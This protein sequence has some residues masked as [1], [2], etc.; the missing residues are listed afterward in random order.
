MANSWASAVP[1]LPLAALAQLATFL[2]G[3]TEAKYTFGG[4]GKCFPT[5]PGLEIDGVGAAVHTTWEI[6]AAK[7]HLKNLE[8][9]SGHDLLA[10]EI[11]AKFGITMR[12]S[13]LL[14]YGPGGHIARHRDTETHDRVF[15][16]VAIQLLL[17]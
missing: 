1:A 11:I 2:A 4:R 5:Q 7:V 10:A 14:L 3:A 6:D 15:A 8:W 17:R 9:V 12:L 16:M 13:K